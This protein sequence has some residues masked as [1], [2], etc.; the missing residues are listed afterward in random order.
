MR[1]ALEAKGVLEEDEGDGKDKL[2]V[3]VP[4]AEEEDDLV[5]LVF[6][7]Q[8][9]FLIE[10]AVGP[11]EVSGPHVLLSTCS[12]I[13]ARVSGQPWLLMCSKDGYYFIA[14]GLIC[15]LVA[16]PGHA[17]GRQLLITDLPCIHLAW[18]RFLILLLA[19]AHIVTLDE[20]VA[21]LVLRRTLSKLCLLPCELSIVLAALKL[22]AFIKFNPPFSGLGLGGLDV[23]VGEDLSI[24][25]YLILSSSALV[26]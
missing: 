1:V 21:I 25:Q 4:E 12:F 20:R 8:V 2:L 15:V 18:Q 19:K 6:L 17:A 22:L 3:D 10:L 11:I 14:L 5:G 24:F 23:F 16:I 7:I 13:D 9:H 26:L